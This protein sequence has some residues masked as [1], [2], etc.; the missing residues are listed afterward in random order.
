MIVNWTTKK[1]NNGISVG[2]LLLFLLLW[3][4]YLWI[5]IDNYSYQFLKVVDIGG[6]LFLSLG[7]PCIPLAILALSIVAWKKNMNVLKI[8]LLVLFVPSIF[9]ASLMSAIELLVHPTVCSYTANIQNFGKFDEDVSNM[10]ELNPVV[11]FPD[12]LPE[13][14][15]NTQY[16]YYYQSSSS[17]VIYIGV[18]WSVEDDYTFELWKQAYATNVRDGKPYNSGCLQKGKLFCNAV[19]LNDQ[20][21]QIGFVITSQE[22]LLPNSF[23]DLVKEPRTI[24]EHIRGTV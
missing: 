17:D 4:G 10:L 11:A 18:T 6:F 16:C 7:V 2:V 12:A 24:L 20:T 13:N 22:E 14:V 8:V 19:L 21:N 23:D 9:F 15:D 5:H 3:G 1:V